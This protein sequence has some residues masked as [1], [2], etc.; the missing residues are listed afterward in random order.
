MTSTQL[1]C[2]LE[3]AAR[4]SFTE[5]AQAL[6]VT[7]PALSRQI[8]VLEQELGVTLFDRRNNRISLTAAGQ[9]LQR[10]LRPLAA[11]YEDA[12]E[13]VRMVA[14]GVSGRLTVGVPDDMELDPLLRDALT[15]L[16]RENPALDLRIAHC[17]QREL[18]NGLRDGRFDLICA[19]APKLKLADDRCESFLLNLQPICAAVCAEHALAGRESVSVQELSELTRRTP[20]LMPA[21]TKVGGAEGEPDSA[22]VLR[23]EPYA[24]FCKRYLSSAAMELYLRAGAGI[25]FVTPG[26][27]LA[28][29]DGVSTVRIEPG[30]LLPVSAIW[31]RGSTNPALRRLIAQLEA[32]E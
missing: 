21:P 15:A 18:H 12:I 28:H 7:Q 9:E 27:T 30:D 22:A 4:E 2:F 13:A 20:L 16:L 26:S 23:G 10:R 32:E 31:E 25:A 24:S 8:A 5:A 6:F 14:A 3:S 11:G 17:P 1:R 19:L 29:A